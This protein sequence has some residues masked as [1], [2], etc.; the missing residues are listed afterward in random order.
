LHLLN[1]RGGGLAFCV[2]ESAPMEAFWLSLAI[3]FLAELG[4]K[5]QLV[6]LCLAARFRAAV[7]LGGVFAATLCVHLF[8]VGI[9]AGAA[10]LIPEAYV[11]IAAGIAFIVFGAWTLRGDSVDS[12][13]CG[14]VN[15]RSPFWITF[16][17]FFLAEL[18][19]KT[20]LSTV[21][22][23]AGRAGVPVW[24]GSS[25]GMVASDGLAIGVG[26]IMGKRLPERA[27]KV[28][29]ACVFFGF[30]VFSAVQGA[31]RLPV[32]VWGTL[33]AAAVAAVM[34]LAWARAERRSVPTASGE[35]AEEVAASGRTVV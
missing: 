7:V 14:R 18:G 31:S 12:E 4:D 32:A 9:G 23:A 27:V 2:F 6:A 3:V 33:L 5:T 1:A 8:S 22:L 21:T 10:R 11:R 25:L 17:T 15:G 20:M 26:R 29:A 34:L 28:G 19:D 24:L 13:E 30:G 16:I 35:R